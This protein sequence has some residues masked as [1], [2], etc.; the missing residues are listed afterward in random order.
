M[1]RGGIMEPFIV[2]YNDNY[3][4]HWE[5]KRRG[6]ENFYLRCKE[7]GEAEKLAIKLNKRDADRARS[8]SK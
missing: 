3:D 8:V 6:A 4:Y 7:Y 5:V 1:V 2:E